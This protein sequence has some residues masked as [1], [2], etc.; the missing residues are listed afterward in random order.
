MTKIITVA[1]TAA[2]LAGV[3]VANAQSSNS[4]R[5]PSPDAPAVNQGGTLPEGV[6]P[7]GFESLES[8]EHVRQ[9]HRQSRRRPARKSQRDQGTT[10][11]PVMDTP[12]GGGAAPAPAR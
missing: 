8:T 7:E 4:H 10:K 3:T 6:V 5:V 12:P 2:L 9:R 1:A 11:G